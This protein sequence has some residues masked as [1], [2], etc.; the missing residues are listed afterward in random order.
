MTGGGSGD[1][2]RACPTWYH[3]T[4]A[5]F[6]ALP[7]LAG[8]VEADVCVI[9]GGLAGVTAALALGERGYTVALLE[10]ARLGNGASGR[11][12]GHLVTGFSCDMSR[13]RRQAG[14]AASRAL[15]A[16]GLEAIEGIHRKA[17]RYRIDCD[18]RRGYLFAA[19]TDR[20][21]AALEATAEEWDVL[22]GYGG[23]RLLPA[24]RLAHLVGTDR[25]TGGLV[26]PGG[27]QIHPLNYL[28][29][30]ASA[31]RAAGVQM[32]E[33]S[34]ALSVDRERGRNLVRTRH[35]R[36]GA[37]FVI[38]AGNA[39]LGRLVPRLQGRLAPVA[40]YVGV[41]H[42]LAGTTARDLM[43]GN[44]AVSDCA[45]APDYYRLTADRRLLFGAGA[46]Y[47]PGAPDTMDDFLR[48]RIARL[49]PALAPVGLDRSW[50]GLIGI[51]RSRIPDIGRSGPDMFH[52]QGFSGQGVALTG[53]AGALIADAVA[54]TAERFDV[55]AAL[56]HR[57]F[58]GGPLRRPLL[59]LAMSWYR[60]RDRLG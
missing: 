56:R 15:W 20:H 47:G 31:A 29:G 33:H 21:R 28:L 45:P 44:V 37:R 4:A 41:T 9:G 2:D 54:G 17:G 5:P 46:R 55:F 43:P 16:M 8:P 50:S 25:Y 27:G 7:A 36:V 10:A 14:L 30:L 48:R 1:P 35:G 3:A 60:L 39:Y 51:T 24:D 26:D 18:L 57:R 59:A 58:P 53:L 19:G 38:F 49:F 23:L 42:P 11:N 40:S 52:A 22:Y 13:I 12:G 6:P 32:F 34:A